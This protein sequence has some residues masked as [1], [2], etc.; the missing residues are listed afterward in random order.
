MKGFFAYW[1]H[2]YSTSLSW[3]LELG[4][5]IMRLDTYHS[6][7]WIQAFPCKSGTNFEEINHF[8]FISRC[9]ICCSRCRTNSKPCRMA[10]SQEIS[11]C[12]SLAL[13]ACYLFLY[14]NGGWTFL[15][16]GEEG[17]EGVDVNY[18]I[19]S[20]ATRNMIQIIKL[21]KCFACISLTKVY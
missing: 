14:D 12:L 15:L 8:A 16:F 19:L 6:V 13:E 3:I 2:V 4:W 9:K 20:P 18:T 5:I 17:V 21:H 7:D 11:F 1:S 10:L